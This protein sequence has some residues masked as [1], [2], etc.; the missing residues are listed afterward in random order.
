MTTTKT[1]TGSQLIDRFGRRIDYLRISVTDRCDLRCVYCMPEDVTF[2][3]RQELL[4]DDEILRLVRLFTQLGFS[5]FRLTGGEPFMRRDLET[6]VSMLT[7]IPGIEDM[8]LTTNGS[9]PLERINSIREA[10]LRRMTVSLDALDD[11]TFIMMND[12]KVPVERVMTF[13]FADKK[14][15]AGR[16][17]FVLLDRL[18]RVDPAEGVSRTIPEEAVRAV[19][20]GGG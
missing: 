17:R 9:F 19:L 14:A 11:P 1:G 6:L 8:A 10:G 16:A 13:L 4:Q 18:G 3:P 5:K 15:R 20:A 7:E 12:M 2:R